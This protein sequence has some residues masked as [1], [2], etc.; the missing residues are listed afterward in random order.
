MRRAPLWA[1]CERTNASAED[2]AESS[3][4]ARSV[5]DTGGVVL[6]PAFAGLGAPYWD[7]EARAAILG[8]T[9]GTSRAHIV[10]AGLDAIARQCTDLVRALRADAELPAQGPATALLAAVKAILPAGALLTKIDG[11]AVSELWKQRNS[12]QSEQQFVVLQTHTARA[13]SLADTIA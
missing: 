4:V 2:A 8:M 3:D 12:G 7:P 5:E 10:R 13:C 1:A 6:V 11:R 9:R